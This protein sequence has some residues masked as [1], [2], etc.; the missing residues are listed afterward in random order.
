MRRKRDEKNLKMKVEDYWRLA[1]SVAVCLAVG[2]AGGFFTASE[3][4]TWYALLAKPSFSPPNWL[5]APVWTVLYVMMGTAFFL[6]WRNAKKTE[7]ANFKVGVVLF[8]AQLFLNFSWSLV[9]F[10]MHSLGGAFIVIL[11]LWLFILA[12]LVWFW[13][14]SRAASVLLVPYIAWVS[15]AS[16]LNYAVWTLN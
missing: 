1:A 4:P 13:R 10:G 5:F 15:F 11:L 16:F 12:N 14:V 6:F 3:I 9:F 7:N 2:F 8:A